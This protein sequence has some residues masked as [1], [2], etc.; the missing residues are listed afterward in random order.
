M[1]L[2]R[3][4]NNVRT[5]V[6]L[7][8]GNG[9]LGHSSL[10]VSVE[11]LSTVQ[12]NSVV[13]LTC[14]RQESWNVNQRYDR[15]IEGVAETNETCTLTAGVNVEHTCVA[16][17][18][19]GYD[20]YAL[21]VEASETYDD[22]LSELRLY[23]EELAIIGNSSDNLVH[24]VCLVGVLRDNLVQSV[25]HT[26][27]RI[28]A[29]LRR[30]CLHVVRWDVAQQSLNHLQTLFLGLSCEVGYTRLGSVNRCTTQVLLVD[31]LAGNGLYNLW[32]CEEH[33]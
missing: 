21:T 20:T 28:G 22:V 17:R 32:T 26:V 12:D 3:A 19:V 31:I 4:H 13:L 24:I 9:N 11:Q 7:T 15:N 23:L 6:R 16:S 25:L 2:L 27:D 14:T 8:Q 33:V 5:T 29:R 1:Q 30:S 10:A 18:L